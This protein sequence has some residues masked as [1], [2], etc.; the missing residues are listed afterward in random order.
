[1]PQDDAYERAADRAA[2]A[3]MSG[4]LAPWIDVLPSLGQRRRAEE[5]D[6][7]RGPRDGGALEAPPAVGEVLRS[8][9]RPLAPVVRAFMESRFGH[10]FSEVRVHDDAAAAASARAVRAQ[11][12][13]VGRDVVFAAGMYAPDRHAGRRLLAHELAHVVQQSRSPD[14]GQGA[15]WPS[16]ATYALS[17]QRTPD[18]AAP[19]AEQARPAGGDAAVVPDDD[20]V[21][22]GIEWPAAGE[23][24]LRWWRDL[25]LSSVTPIRDLTPE[26]QP[27]AWSNRTLRAQRLLYEHGATLIEGARLDRDGV[28]GPRTFLA[29]ALAAQ[30]EHHPARAQIQG[31]GVDLDAIRRAESSL[32]RARAYAR[33][34]ETLVQLPI[35]V[36]GENTVRFYDAFYSMVTDDREILDALLFGGAAPASL[37]RE[38]RIELLRRLYGQQSRRL[39]GTASLVRARRDFIHPRIDVARAVEQDRRER[40]DRRHYF[41]FVAQSPHRVSAL[42]SY[43]GIWTALDQAAHRLSP[44][45]RA[46]FDEVAATLARQ[47]RGPASAAQESAAILVAVYLPELDSA[48]RTATVDAYLTERAERERAERAR[49][50]EHNRDAARQRADRLVA[51][52]AAED[53]YRPVRHAGFRTEL[54]R[55]V[56][57]G[58]FFDSVLDDLA[59]REGRWLDRLFDAVEG[60]PGDAALGSLVEASRAGRYRDH[61]RV[62]RALAALIQRH[63]EAREHGYVVTDGGGAVLLDGGTRLEAGQ[64]AGDIDSHYLRDE[65]REQLSPGAQ[66]RLN[67]ALE[68]E[69]RAY[70]A[71]LLAGQEPLRGQEEIGQHLLGLAWQAARID[72]DQDIEDV[73]WQESLR[74]LGVRRAAE[75]GDGVPRYDVEYEVVQRVVG[76]SAGGTPWTPVADSR[77]WRGESDFEYAL[78]WYGYSQTADVVQALAVAVA[79]GAVVAV[80]WEVGVLAALA[81]AGGGAVPVLASIGFSVALHMLT[82]RRWTLEGLL[83][84]GIEGYLAA[85]GF[86]VFAPVGRAVSRMILPAAL[87][88]VAFRRVVAAWLLRHGTVGALTGGTVGPA[89]LFVQDLVRVA[90]GGDFSA[91]AAYLR[92]AAWGVLIGAVVEIGGSALLTPLFRAADHTVLARLAD[93]ATM[94]RGREPPV[95]PSQWLSEVSVSL[96]QFRAFLGNIADDAIANGIFATVRERMQQ[97]GAAV[98]TGVRGTLQREV[99][100][101]A[102]VALTRDAAAGLE[103]LLRLGRATLSDDAIATLLQQARR[104][105]ERIDPYLRFL[106]GLDEAAAGGLVARNQLRPLLDAE[107]VLAL[108][109]RR[110]SAEVA[111]LMSGRFAGSLDDLEQ[112]ARRVNALENPLADRVLDALRARGTAVTPRS[113]LRIA[114]SGAGLDDDVL[115]GLQRLLDGGDAGRLEAVLEAMANDQVGAFLRSAQTATAPEREAM[116]RVIASHEAPHVAWAARLPIAEAESLLNQLTPSARAVITD[117]TA[118]EAQAMIAALG[119]DRVNRALSLGTAG[120]LRGSH[121]HT[122]R[123]RVHDASIRDWLDWVEAHAN[124][125]GRVQRFADALRSGAADI[126]VGAPLDAASLM[127]DSNALFAIEDLMRGANSAGNPITFASLPPNRQDA[128]N[129]LRE[130]RGLGAYVDPP[131]GTL[132]TF[133]YIVGPGADLRAGVVVSGETLEGVAAVGPSPVLPRLRGIDVA[134]S[135]TDYPL[136]IADLRSMKVGAE[137]GA[138]DR[139]VVADA[140]FA[141][142]AGGGTRRLIT[143]DQDIAVALAQHFAT[144]VR[145]APTG[146]KATWWPQLVRDFPSGRFTITIRGHSLEILFRGSTSR[147]T[148]AP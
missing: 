52:I 94:L 92:A 39:H 61:P 19:A 79:V 41:V 137:K 103:R 34:P 8:P 11:A 89:S 7:R 29:L 143:T 71:R 69:S 62:R 83:L 139:A 85:V 119:I 22:R 87:E 25:S 30:D 104:T 133:E 14:L 20:L 102:S 91:F 2:D 72:P 28:L 65:D 31:L 21:E 136:V 5:D 118:A 84:A 122:L 44:R 67:Q 106:A 60:I 147:S 40:L 142:L 76:G 56:R 68:A 3:V 125:L 105:P 145:F 146:P 134:R 126:P 35:E 63:G 45:E 53:M 37:R 80:A 93:I 95:T 82:H 24:N 23:A 70:F 4:G 101:L 58:Q 36:L 100:D 107:A 110:N 27:R 124:R 16:G 42:E 123:Q 73:E 59:A 99:I 128:L 78:F 96:A 130:A 135:H 81:S 48:Q 129:A 18:G 114:E 43:F 50:D 6:R 112:F 127:L 113:L 47:Q 120:P 132:P 9:G 88:Q 12:Y 10:D 49:I 75:S 140:M 33:R 32:L 109:S 74:L 108:A 17:L 131:T 86:R 13:T 111:A 77:G 38:D 46:G 141:D 57:E 64:V 138:R 90:R 1:M 97:A 144:P 51:L 117:I 148:P 116:Q 98:F 15:S 115:G 66:Q 121:L 55:A 26:R 54:E